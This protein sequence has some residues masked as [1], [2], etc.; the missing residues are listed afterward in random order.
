MSL[1]IRISLMVTSL[2]AVAV[3]GTATLSIWN[4]HRNALEQMKASS[5]LMAQFLARI[6]QFSEAIP[7]DLENILGE[8]VQSQVL[9]QLQETMEKKHLAQV[10]IDNPAI[11]AIRVVDRNLVA[12]ADVVS[13]TLP[14]IPEGD[15]WEDTIN[16]KQVLLQGQSISY[17]KGNLLKVM[18]PIRDTQQTT[19]GAAF[20][21]ISTLPLRQA[22]Q[23][24]LTRVTIMAAVI[25]LGGL[26]ISFLMAQRITHPIT[27]LARSIAPGK[28]IPSQLRNLAAIAPRPDEVG[29]LARELQRRI[30][31]GREREQR[32]TQTQHKL[33]QSEAYFRTLIENVSDVILILDI[34]GKIRYAS[35][36]SISVLG[37]AP[38]TLSDQPL[39]KFVQPQDAERVK[40][41]LQRNLKQLGIAPAFE[42]RF[43][44]QQRY[45]PVLEAISNNLLVGHLA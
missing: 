34:T 11:V 19:T 18:V 42:F 44:H 35:P 32:I 21:C 9:E 12:Q 29:L 31:E 41:I 40:A 7:A 38:T 30:A 6:A 4:A 2:L 5:L 20:L 17:V 37:Y 43:K 27:Q 45:W 8:Q 23:D 13:T 16:L 10:V 28:P 26:L 24:D 25:L 39:L 3:V 14:G 22:M 1:R 36:A 15:H 33:S